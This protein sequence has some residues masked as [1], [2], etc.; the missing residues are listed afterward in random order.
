MRDLSEAARRQGELFGLGARDWADEQERMALPLWR[1]A[2]QAAHVERGARLL[3]AGCGSGGALLLA[4][5]LGAEVYGVD[6]SVNM[7]TIAR[8][9]LPTADFRIG[10]LKIS[11]FQ[12]RSSKPL[13]QLTLLNSTLILN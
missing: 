1:A 3:D 2:L 10:E 11:L 5:E 9:R 6:P 12:T 4:A 7:L 8:E 13:S